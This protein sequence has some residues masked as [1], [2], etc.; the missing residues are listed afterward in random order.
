M[1]LLNLT[2]KKQNYATWTKAKLYLTLIPELAAWPQTRKAI[3]EAASQPVLQGDS[4]ILDEPWDFSLAP[5]D[6]GYWRVIDILVNTGQLRNTIE[7]EIGGQGFKQRLDC[8]IQGNGPEQLEFADCLVI[9]SGCLLPMIADKQ[10]NHHVMGDLENP[11]YVE[12]GEGGTGGDRVGFAFT[13]FADTGFTNFIY[14]AA[15]HGIDLT[16]N[17]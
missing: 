10:S 4:K 9:N 1:N 11:I 15:T 8:F 12:T 3:K 7:G 2:R 5:T 17:P 6:E 13:F 14:D 16:P